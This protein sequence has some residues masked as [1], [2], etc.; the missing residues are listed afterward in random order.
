VLVILVNAISFKPYFTNNTYI[1][2]TQNPG[3]IQTIHNSPTEKK[4]DT[5][6]KRK[7][8]ERKNRKRRHNGEAY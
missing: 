6:P 7:K 2:P 8:V 5:T 4:K 3:N 1:N